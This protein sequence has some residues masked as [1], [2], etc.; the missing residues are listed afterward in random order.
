M[1]HIELLSWSLHSVKNKI[2]GHFQSFSSF[3]SHF[4]DPLYVHD[5]F[6][7]THSRKKLKVIFYTKKEKRVRKWKLLQ[8]WKTLS[9]FQFRLLLLLNIFIITGLWP[10]SDIVIRWELEFATIYV[11]WHS[12]IH[13]FSNDHDTNVKILYWGIGRHIKVDYI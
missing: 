2:P 6:Y 12:L 7:L 10:P 5:T 3:Q 9:L 8:Q 4:P 11:N 13:F 1:F